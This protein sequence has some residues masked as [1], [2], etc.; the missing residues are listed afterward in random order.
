[1]CATLLA[2]S[3]STE[4]NSIVHNLTRLGQLTI[5][6]VSALYTIR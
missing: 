1:M 6:N 2:L 5:T 4:N 3:I